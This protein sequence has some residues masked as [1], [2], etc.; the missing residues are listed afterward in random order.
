MAKS[1]NPVDAHRKA[2]RKQELKRNKQKREHTKEISTVKKD[3][4][5]IE[6]DIRRL[7]QQAQKGQLSKDDREQLAHL[8]SELARINKA[9]N[10]YVEAHPEHRKYVFP[11][12][13]QD[14]STRDDDEDTT[15]G[16]YD[17]N[18][19]LKHPE[20]S[21][22]YDPVF[23]PFGAPPPGMPYREKPEYALARM[24]PTPEEIAAFRPVGAEDDEDEDDDEDDDEDIA[25]PA[26][27]PPGAAAAAEK[28]DEKESSDD[29]DS[30]DDDDIPLPP[31]PPPPRP[32]QPSLVSTSA[33]TA[34]HTVAIARP[35]AA[36]HFPPPHPH[37][38]PPRPNFQAPPPPPP[39]PHPSHARP[40]LPHGPKNPRFPARPPPPGTHMLD[41]L[42][43]DG[44]PNRAF[45]QGGGG[46][47]QHGFGPIL[48]QGGM[49]PPPPPP[50]APPQQL[51]AGPSPFF[52]VPGAAYPS[53]AAS[54]TPTA[55][56]SSTATI[57]AAPQLRDLK[58]EATAFV[59]LAMR[60]KLKQQQATLA[61]AGLASINAARG[62]EG[63]EG[64]AMG[65][66]GEA[67]APQRKRTLMDE[68]RERGIGA[69]GAAARS[70]SAGTAPSQ[71]PAGEGEVDDYERFR[72]EM[73]DLL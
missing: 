26:G 14:A 67:V 27:P 5:P 10:D 66:G 31:G 32:N 71:G 48:P 23:N 16:L 8:K 39:H 54:Q 70:A 68:M 28:D 58:K 53:V 34:R 56:T 21:L 44:A 63:E 65:E 19:R 62:A 36:S 7:S 45:Q 43:A 4:R 52:A 30:D 12:R 9:K 2:Q 25:M 72:E 60:K 41:P 55:S 3:T 38:L 15:P 57:S 61:K 64:A 69:P 37:S 18:G 73:A 29:S 51:P 59:P 50:S 33:G 1:S 42:N 24:G 6:A 17:K 49:P 11:E 13:P 47:Q 22:Y 35:S 46:P 40:P 20:R